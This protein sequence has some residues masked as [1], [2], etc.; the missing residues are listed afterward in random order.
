[1]KKRYMIIPGLALIG[2]LT[3]GGTYYFLSNHH[4]AKTSAIV[5]S[6]G[7]LSDFTD[8]LRQALGSGSVGTVSSLMKNEFGQSLDRE[9][10]KTL[11][12][13][14][15]GSTSK[16]D[17]FMGAIN[18]QSSSLGES[19]EPYKGSAFY[20]DRVDDELVLKVKQIDVKVLVKADKAKLTVNGESMPLMDN[21]ATFTSLPKPLKMVATVDEF[22]D[23]QTLDLIDY[24][25]ANNKVKHEAAP[26]SFI[27]FKKGYGEKVDVT[28]N[29]PKAQIFVNGKDTGKAIESERGTTVDG[30]RKGDVIR[31]MNENGD[32]S[33]V[34]TVD[35]LQHDVKLEF[36]TNQPQ[37]KQVMGLADSTYKAVSENTNNF[38][39]KITE[40]ISSKDVMKIDN[41]VEPSYAA[42]LK[43][44]LSL[45]ANN[46]DSGTFSDVKVNTVEDRNGY[47]VVDVAATFDTKQGEYQEHKPKTIQ[48]NITESGQVAFFSM[49]DRT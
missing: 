10:V 8:E 45:F 24:F 7:E 21:N 29:V 48:L 22:T 31:L 38:L 13:Y 30:L 3:F 14:F 6:S 4:S 5:D 9:Y 40:C 41:Y 25:I 17:K 32:M 42:K 27:M 37:E 47:Y 33:T 18:G 44:D 49:N 1:M 2:M 35:C 39:G 15:E 46:L 12:T 11:C 23:K 28:T 19:V 36:N 26:A 43:E 34:F 20:L 16:V